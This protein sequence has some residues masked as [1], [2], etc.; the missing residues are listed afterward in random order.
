MYFSNLAKLSDS[1]SNN[2]LCKNCNNFTINMKGGGCES[3]K[4]QRVGHNDIELD[5]KK[6]EESLLKYGY[7][8]KDSY[9]NRITALKNVLDNKN[10][11]KFLR[12]INALKELQKSNRKIFD[13]LNKDLEFINQHH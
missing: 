6:E 4:N 7:S 11:S 3:C 12:H 10:K 9:E 1:L 8:I 2:H 5:I 13:K